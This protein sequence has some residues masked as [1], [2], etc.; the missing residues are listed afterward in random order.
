MKEK[1][2]YLEKEVDRLH[3]EK[4]SLRTD[5]STI[6]RYAREKYFMKAPNEEVYVFDTVYAPKPKV[7]E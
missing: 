5:S 4:N 2:D 7:V 6:E 1:I 3:A